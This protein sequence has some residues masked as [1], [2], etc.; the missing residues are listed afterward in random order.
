MDNLTI[1]I[2]NKARYRKRASKTQQLG[3]L[4]ALVKV[5]GNVA[6][7]ATITDIIADLYTAHFPTPPKLPKP[8]CHPIWWDWVALARNQSGTDPRMNLYSV[9]EMPNGDVVATDGHRLHVRT[10][11][12]FNLEEPVS[13]EYVKKT[14]RWEATNHKDFVAYERLLVAHGREYTALNTISTKVIEVSKYHTVLELTDTL[15]NK[16]VYVN[17]HYYDEAIMMM[18]AGA[19]ITI[20]SPNCNVIIQ[21]GYM[22][23]VIVPIRS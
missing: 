15:T 20:G 4:N 12:G 13:F 23:A 11:S 17:K 16:S 5:L 1:E 22:I 10:N 21:E 14:K 6:L 2:L 18:G 19:T 3:A 9:W 7:P 8:S